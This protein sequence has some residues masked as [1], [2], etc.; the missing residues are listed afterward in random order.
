LTLDDT[1]RA[2]PSIEIFIPAPLL[3]GPLG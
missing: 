3:H 2:D 1:L